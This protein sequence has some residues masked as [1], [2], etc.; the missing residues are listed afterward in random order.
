MIDMKITNGETNIKAFD[1]LLEAN[2]QANYAWSRLTESER[3]N[4]TIKVGHVTEADLQD[5]STEDDVIDWTL[6]KSW[7]PV[8][9]GFVGY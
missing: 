6:I 1:T 5:F 7:E 8:N 4:R 2:K 9:N 3:K